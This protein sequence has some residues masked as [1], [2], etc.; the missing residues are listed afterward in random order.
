MSVPVKT[1][2]SQTYQVF[3][4]G[5]ALHPELFQIKA[6]RVVK[7]GA[8]E[9]EAWLMQGMHL[10]RF[11]HRTMCA[12][13]LLV[14]H[15]GNL[16]S[17]GA[18]AAFLCAGERDFEHKFP[19]DRVTYM[20]T[21]QTEQLSENLYLATLNELR[22]HAKETEALVHQWRDEAGPC[23]SMLDIQRYAKEVHAQAFHLLAQGGLVLRTQ[24]IFEHE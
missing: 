1:N 11:E 21:V 7:H 13:E 2:V 18:V 19:K 23:L 16:P 10:L 9:F 22:A 12:S 6:R 20:S 24:T 8:Y 3:L 14:D 5:R 4:Y 17:T 15:E